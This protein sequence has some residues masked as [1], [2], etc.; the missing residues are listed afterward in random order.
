MQNWLNFF[1]DDRCP[2]KKSGGKR[3][4]PVQD[5][6]FRFNHRKRKRKNDEFQRSNQSEAKLKEKRNS[7]N[8]WLMCCAMRGKKNPTRKESKLI[9]WSRKIRE[10]RKRHRPSNNRICCRSI[11]FFLF[12]S[13][14]DLFLFLFLSLSCRYTLARFYVFCLDAFSCKRTNRAFTRG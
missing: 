5:L 11:L 12:L 2:E 13:L 4:L 3:S 6:F 7:V 8:Q 1:G 9:H 14:G 10:K